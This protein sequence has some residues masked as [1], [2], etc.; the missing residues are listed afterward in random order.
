MGKRHIDQHVAPSFSW[1]MPVFDEAEFI[2][3]RI[4]RLSVINLVCQTGENSCR[5]PSYHFPLW[6]SVAATNRGKRGRKLIKAGLDPNKI[7]NT[8]RCYD[9]EGKTSL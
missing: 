1:K 5:A 2:S 3:I 6:A 8:E 9:S 7:I 4:H